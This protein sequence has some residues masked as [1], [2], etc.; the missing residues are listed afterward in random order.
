MRAERQ[1]LRADGQLVAPN[2]YRESSSGHQETLPL[3]GDV[4]SNSSE[5]VINKVTQ[6]TALGYEEL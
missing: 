4:P 1:P 3:F 2:G 5:R 6:I